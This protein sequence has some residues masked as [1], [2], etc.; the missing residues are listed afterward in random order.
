MTVDRLEEFCAA[1]ARADLDS[2][3]D[4]MS[5]DCVYRASVGSEPGETFVGPAAV[6]AGFA[7]MLAHDVGK[8]AQKGRCFVCGDRGVGQ[9]SYVYFEA[10]RRIELFGCDLFEFD[11]DKIRVKDA[12]RK[13]FHALGGP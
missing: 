1:W 2:L 4:F 6:R 8:E 13:T 7:R 10:G 3:M 5:D 9:W 11:G 12:F